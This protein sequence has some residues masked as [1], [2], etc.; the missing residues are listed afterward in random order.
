[1][2]GVWWGMK[3]VTDYK[4]GA[5]E[6]KQRTLTSSTLYLFYPV[7]LPD[8]NPCLPSHPL[9]ISSYPLSSTFFHASISITNDQVRQELKKAVDPNLLKVCSPDF[10]SDK[11]TGVTFFPNP[12][13]VRLRLNPRCFPTPTASLHPIFSPPSR[14][15]GKKNVSS[16]LGVTTAWW[17]NQ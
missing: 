9:Q 13:N 16:N 2:H 17:H 4:A 5:A 3:T 15:I 12:N 7:W 1:M 10:S 8:C 11:D 6:A 14:E